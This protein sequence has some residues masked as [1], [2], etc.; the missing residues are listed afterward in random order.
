MTGQMAW[1]KGK[2]KGKGKGIQGSSFV[3][4]FQCRL[5]DSDFNCSVAE[6]NLQIG[7]NFGLTL[8]LTQLKSP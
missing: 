4:P 2:C 5:F 7:Q 3:A 1:G 6:V 8:A